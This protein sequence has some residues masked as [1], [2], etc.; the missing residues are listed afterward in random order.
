MSLVQIF[1]LGPGSWRSPR[2]PR[3]RRQ[4]LESYSPSEESCIS[5]SEDEAPESVSLKSSKEHFLSHARSVREA[6]SKVAT[7]EKGRRRAHDTLLKAQAERRQK[8][9]AAL[10]ELRPNRF[11][12]KKKRTLSE[13]KRIVFEEEDVSL[14]EE[15]ETVVSP[16]TKVVKLTGNTRKVLKLNI[17][18]A[19]ELVRRRGAMQSRGGVGKRVHASHL[20]A[21]KRV[22]RPAAVFRLKSH[23]DFSYSEKIRPGEKLI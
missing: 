18:A 10:A 12:G 1:G 13:P 7:E 11:D 23:D 2:M 14:P 21:S 8:V 20:M 17:K 4:S 19:S 22:G 9:E 5:G 16:G 15:E 6:S 3:D